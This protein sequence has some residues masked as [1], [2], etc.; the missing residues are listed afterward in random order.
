MLASAYIS[1]NYKKVAI[2]GFGN[3]EFKN[4]NI[5]S[6]ILENLNRESLKLLE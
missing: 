6:K 3:L 1:N 4:K 2:L 5:V